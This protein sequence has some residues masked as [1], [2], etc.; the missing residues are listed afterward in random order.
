MTLEMESKKYANVSGSIK[1]IPLSYQAVQ[2]QIN[3]AVVIKGL[4]VQ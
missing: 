2:H 3:Y 4:Q 1:L